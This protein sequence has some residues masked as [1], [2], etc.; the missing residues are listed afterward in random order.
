MNFSVKSALFRFFGFFSIFRPIFLAWEILHRNNFVWRM[1]KNDYNNFFPHYSAK[2]IKIPYLENHHISLPLQRKP[3]NRPKINFVSICRRQFSLTYSVME[4][5]KKFGC[6][7]HACVCVC[8]CVFPFVLRM[9]GLKKNW[10]FLP[11]LG[12]FG[13]F[14]LYSLFFFFFNFWFF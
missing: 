11:F 6:R 1:K 5:K 14:S 4:W 2:K 8:V 10:A 3:C 13:S 9:I 12:L 7:M